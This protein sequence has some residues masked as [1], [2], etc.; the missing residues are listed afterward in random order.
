MTMNRD[1]SATAIN[2]E[3][4]VTQEVGARTVKLFTHNIQFSTNNKFV[5]YIND[6]LYYII[7]QR[8]L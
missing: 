6:I 5:N 2:N 1:I 3:N 4:C 8:I 7:R